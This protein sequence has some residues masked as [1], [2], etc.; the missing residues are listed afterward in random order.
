MSYNVWQD[1]MRPEPDRDLIAVCERAKTS[2]QWH[3]FNRETGAIRAR[4]CD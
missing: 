4:E 3:Q 2:F 1:R